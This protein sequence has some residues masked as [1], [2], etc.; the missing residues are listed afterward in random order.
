VLAVVVPVL[1]G[2]LVS[3]HS[4]VENFISE[5]G[6]VGTPWGRAV[7]LGGFLPTGLASIGVAYVGAAFAPCDPGCP[8]FPTSVRQLVHNLLG[9]L[10]YL[11]GGIGLLVFAGTYF[12]QR[13]DRMAQGILFVAGVVVLATFAGIADP[14]L[15]AWH[16]LIQ[17]VGETALFGS[18]LLI[19]WRLA[20]GLHG[21]GCAPGGF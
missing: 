3:G 18:L 15:G 2:L 20:S 6:A 11:G 12:R 16:G 4:H 7:S 19:G 8:A 1:G 21:R 9:I 5:L 17:R 14:T 10:E 13:R